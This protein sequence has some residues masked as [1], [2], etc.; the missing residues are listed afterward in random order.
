MNDVRRPVEGPSVSKPYR[1]F[2]RTIEECWSPM[3]IGAYAT[4]EEAV[5]EAK[6]RLDRRARVMKGPTQLWP[7]ALLGT[8][9]Q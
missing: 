9:R 8:A 5:A 3:P 2:K 1:T 4:E 7:P 6:G